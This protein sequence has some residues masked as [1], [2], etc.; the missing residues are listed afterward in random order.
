MSTSLPEYDELDATGLAELVRQ[1]DVSPAE[2][3]E[4]A[5]ERIEERDPAIHAVIHRAFEQARQYARG[6]IPQGPFTGVPFLLKDLLAAWAGTPMTHGSRFYGDWAPDRNSTLVD[7]FLASG[8]ILLGKTNLP[9]LALMPVTENVRFG[10]TRNPWDLSRTPGGSSGGAA[11]A[12]AA[13]M[14][15]MASASDGGGS[16]RMPSSCCGL[17]GFKPGRGRNPV[18]PLVGEVWA[19]CSEEHVITRSVRDSARMLD[20]TCGPAPGERCLLPRPEVPFAQEVG[21]DPGKLRIAFMAESLLGEGVHA[22]CRAALEDACALLE[23]LGH[24]VVEAAPAIDPREF[25]RA[26]SYVIFAA[27][28]GDVRTA[29][30][31]V[32]RKARAGDFERTNWL[33]RAAG[34]ALTAGEYDDALRSLHRIA[35][36]LGEFLAQHDAWV[37]PTL[38]A[39]PLAIGEFG[40]KGLLALA[41][42]LIGR[43]GLGRVGVAV[44]DRVTPLWKFMPY[45]QFAN[46]GGLPSMNVPLYW[47]AG[48]LPIGVTLTGPAQSEG[49]L[50]RLASQLEAARPWAVRRPPQTIAG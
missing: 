7:R 22:D 36:T 39:P 21:R 18:G 25:R 6:P 33:L 28:A 20:A 34:E 35:F 44:A 12:V 11:A 30:T 46:V 31:R 43:L 10:A 32:G 38:A 13:R 37:T 9:E 2:L 1:G 3:V 48:G 26:Y 8:V 23:S 15:P 42:S 14:V 45:T 24:E 27:V 49:M 5:I 47:N 16:I 29:E 19:G 4:V 17:F 50:F 40:S 41:E